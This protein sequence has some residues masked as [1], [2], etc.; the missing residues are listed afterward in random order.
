MQ[1]TVSDVHVNV[2]LTNL[3]LMYDQEDDA[4]VADKVFPVISVPNKSD[5]Y[6]IYNKGD[7]NR[8]G[9]MQR[10]GPG[11]ESAG[12]GYRLDTASYLAEVWALHK[13]IADQT[14][15]NYDSMLQ[16]DAEATRYLA[17]MARLNRETQWAT[18]YFGPGIW[19]INLTGVASAP[20]AGQFIQWN[21]PTS[22][23][24]DDI[25]N[26][27]TNV[28]L[29]GLYR[30]N[31]LVLA[32]YVF[33]RLVRHPS[34]IDL[35]KYG[36]TGPEPAI[37]TRSTLAQI[38]ELE[39]VLVMDAI[40][41]T[42]TEDSAW[43]ATNPGTDYSPSFIGGK[44]ALL[45]YTPASPGLMTPGCGYTFA[46]TGLM[47]ATPTGSRIKSFYMNWLESTRVEI[48][49]AFVQKIVS[50]DCGCFFA[51]AVA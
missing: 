22:T 14:R 10:R 39:R 40:Q 3:T 30:P 36:Q 46:W 16:P 38:L 45:A 49:N 13:D 20:T 47:G 32:R 41:N 4:F 1:P 43:T 27:K 33:D 48:D 6:W 17:D 35:I 24:I 44:G 29:Q 25:R 15:A 8:A 34:I 31:T 19:G 26:A 21:D 11:T 23:P 50:K 7:F 12:G 9:V 42:A 2:P 5:L 18:N 37:A 51:N 28:Q